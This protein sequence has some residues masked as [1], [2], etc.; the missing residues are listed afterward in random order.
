MKKEDY[1]CAAVETVEKE[2]YARHAAA[3]TAD[4][5][6]LPVKIISSHKFAGSLSSASTI[7]DSFTPVQTNCM[8]PGKE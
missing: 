8:F 6:R 1:A 2:D 7:P 3:E 4:E 5:C